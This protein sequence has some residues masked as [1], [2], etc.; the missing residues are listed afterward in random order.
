M[1]LKEIAEWYRENSNTQ[2]SLVVEE[3]AKLEKL[4][5]DELPEA[6][7]NLVKLCILLSMLKG[8]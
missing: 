3:V 5:V 4:T 1:T 8:N 7:E 6:G 2:A